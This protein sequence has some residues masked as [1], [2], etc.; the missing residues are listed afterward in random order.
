MVNQD[1]SITKLL[2]SVQRQEDLNLTVCKTSVTPLIPNLKLCEAS[3]KDHAKFKKLNLNYR[4]AIR[5]LNEISKESAHSSK[6]QFCCFKSC[7]SFGE[8]RYD[9]LAQ[10]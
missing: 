4:S 5:L 6:Y 2:R 3:D 1:E 8:A 10:G 9:T 7:S